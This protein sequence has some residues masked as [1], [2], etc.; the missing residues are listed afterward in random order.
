MN[1]ISESAIECLARHCNK[2]EIR[3]LS[4]AIP[5][6]QIILSSLKMKERQE[7][8]GWQVGDIVWAN[9]TGYRFWPALIA[10]TPQPNGTFNP[11]LKKKI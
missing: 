6:F 2:N 10:N 1:S 5:N 11:N 8:I 4:K 7:K 9:V 3:E